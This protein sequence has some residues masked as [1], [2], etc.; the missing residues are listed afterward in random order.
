M[1]EYTHLLKSSRADKGL[2]ARHICQILDIDTGNYSGIENGTR[3]H[4]DEMLKKICEILEIDFEVAQPLKAAHFAEV[5]IMKVV[6]HLN[7]QPVQPI[8][9]G[10]LLPNQ[11]LVDLFLSSC[12]CGPEGEVSQDSDGKISVELPKYVKDPSK[13]FAV[14]AKGDSMTPEINDG[15][16][17]FVYA[18]PAYR[19]KNNDYIVAINADGEATCKKIVRRDGKKYLEAINP[20]AAPDY[21]MELNGEHRCIFK[22]IL[23]E[24]RKVFK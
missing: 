6:K 9:S 17:L 7:G 14:K 4:S 21:P 12:P 18:E 20:K 22:V 2:K 1:S 24:S 16:T 5:D 19:L 11:V 13:V 15:D 3:S 23:A 8:E 10:E